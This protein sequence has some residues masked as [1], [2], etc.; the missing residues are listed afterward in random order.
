MQKKIETLL[1][2]ATMFGENAFIAKGGIQMAPGDQFPVNGNNIP[3]VAQP[4][5]G[6]YVTLTRVG[7]A[8]EKS[9]NFV[10]KGYDMNNC[11]YGTLY[12]NGEEAKWRCDGKTVYT[13]LNT[14][15]DEDF[16]SQQEIYRLFLYPFVAWYENKNPEITGFRELYQKHQ[17]TNDDCIRFSV[18]F[19]YGF[20]KN[21]PDV[22]VKV[23]CAESLC[24]PA[25]DRNIVV[26]AE[27]ATRAVGN[28]LPWQTSTEKP[29]PLTVE[30]AIAGKF[31]LKGNWGKVTEADD[32]YDFTADMINPAE[33][34]AYVDNPDFADN[35]R[36]MIGYIGSLFRANNLQWDGTPINEFM[37][38]HNVKM[39]GSNQQNFSLAGDPGSGKTIL[40]RMMA[41]AFGLPCL[42]IRLGERSE[43]D[44][45]TQEVIATSKGFK[46]LKS[47]L[48]WYVKYGGLV[49]FDDLSNVDPNMF[50]T[51]VGG[52]L[53]SPYE[54]T[55]NQET[56]KRHPMCIM[57]A[58]TNV[59]T[60][61]SQPVNEALLTRFGGHFV[62]ERLDDETFK[63]CIISRAQK[64]SGVVV[65][66]KTQKAIANWTFNVF[67]S[68]SKAIKSVDREAADRLI[69][70]RAAISTAEK[71]LN[72][73]ADG[74][75]VDC[76]RAARQT[77]ANILYT[78]G[79]PTLQKAVA[80]AIDSAPSITI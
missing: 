30:S 78:G 73:I 50:F 66:D 62:V 28:G 27:G 31:N 80:D 57:M 23:A 51:T 26:N 24:E 35:L 36:Q 32:F 48:Y 10:L 44:E 61:G 54:Y 38:Q 19:Q 56:V 40:C 14:D 69:T 34:Q 49:V 1:F 79:N 7:Q 25:V 52:L 67:N 63:K 55:V 75:S 3:S 12:A 13:T 39:A 5:P 42:I 21:T 29:T 6:Q 4:F 17:A 8:V 20:V 58:T 45:M 64:N 47:K 72:A 41:A 2:E 46:S 76:K 71:I 9:P 37:G 16:F 22:E 53:E 59:G 65:K 11:A 43:K 18:A 15:D 70:M 33:L 68:V 60:I 74:Y 77:M